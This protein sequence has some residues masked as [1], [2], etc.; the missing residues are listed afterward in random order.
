MTAR[1]RRYG[2]GALKRML[3]V[4]LAAPALLILSPLLAL[5]AVAVLLG[6]GRPVLFRHQRIGL[7]GRRFLLLKFRSMRSAAAPGLPITGGG[8]PRVTPVGRLLRR[9]KL[10][11]LPQ[12]I[13]I[14]VGDMSVVGPRP[15][16]PRYVAIYDDA[17]REVLTFRPGL[18][19][20]AS[21]AFRNEEELL[22]AVPAGA[23]EEYYLR[24]IMPRKLALNL[25]YIRSASLA[26]DI[27]L[28]WRT[29]VVVILGAAR[30]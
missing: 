30:P 10:D 22:G 26:G 3:D 19:D 12:L 9:T 6:S 16:V 20:P 11:E 27:A 29:I 18:T 7:D 21:L 14:L 5:I 23:R 8:D 4:L 2:R 17:Q 13:N 24:E 1:G 25:E 15:E 28:I